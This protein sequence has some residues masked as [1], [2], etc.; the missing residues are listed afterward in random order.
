MATPFA[1]IESIVNTG[2][3][4]L[5]ANATLSYIDSTGDSTIDGVLR[6]SRNEPDAI[7]TPRGVREITFSFHATD[8]GSLASGTPVT[9][10]DTDY[11]VA[12]IESDKTGWV[13]L[14]LRGGYS[15]SGETVATGGGTTGST[16]GRHGNRRGN[17]A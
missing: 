13:T 15:G 3:G 11:T 14:H 5:L 16:F 10:R 9:V 17:G 12:R 8:L 1:D 4:A 2:M 6:D 7:G